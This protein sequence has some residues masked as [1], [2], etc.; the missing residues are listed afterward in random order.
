MGTPASIRG[1]MMSKTVVLKNS[2]HAG[3]PMIW[4]AADAAD[5]GHGPGQRGHAVEGVRKP[6]LGEALAGE[7]VG[8]DGQ[9]RRGDDEVRARTQ[10]IAHALRDERGVVGREESFDHVAAVLLGLLRDDRA[11]RS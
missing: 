4:R 7:V 10:Q 5:E 8:I 2:A 11:K 9:P 1:R 3:T 6:R